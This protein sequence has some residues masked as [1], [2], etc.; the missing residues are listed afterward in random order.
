MNVFDFPLPGATLSDIISHKQ[1]VQ[2]YIRSAVDPNEAGANGRTLLELAMMTCFEGR[3]EDLVS[4]LLRRG[5]DPNKPSPW[6][7]FVGFLTVSNSASLAKEFI[8]H[9]LRLNDVFEVD[10]QAGGLVEG[11]STLL[12]YACAVR[13]YVAPKRKKVNALA[14]KYA[15]GLGKRRRF[16]DETIALLEAAGAKRAAELTQT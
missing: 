14:N 6:A 10:S 8:D 9:G 7:I 4:D 13:D 3:G 2:E 11:R 15:G 5:A 12:D 1:E 16:I